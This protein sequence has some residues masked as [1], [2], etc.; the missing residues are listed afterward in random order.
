[1]VQTR[2]QTHSAQ[3]VKQ[4]TPTSPLAQ[5]ATHIQAHLLQQGASLAEARSTAFQQI[6]RLV[7]TQGY[8]QAL[9]DTFRF[10]LVVLIA[11]VIAACFIRMRKQTPVV[12]HEIEN[13]E[14]LPFILE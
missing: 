7:Q 8:L 6:A 11:S 3:L 12:F 2:A 9:Q 13:E 4:I 5:L 10:L 1:L 14:S